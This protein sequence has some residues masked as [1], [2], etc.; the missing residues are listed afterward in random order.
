M[1]HTRWFK[2]SI[3]YDSNATIASNSKMDFA[4]KQGSNIVTT[5]FIQERE[6]KKIVTHIPKFK[7]LSSNGLVI[8]KFY[9]ETTKHLNETPK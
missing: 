9:S 7:A 4:G 8:T 2:W 6:E 1:A 3:F 5:S